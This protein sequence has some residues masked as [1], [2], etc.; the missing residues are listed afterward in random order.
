ML[1]VS[2][3]KRTAVVCETN[4]FG[5]VQLAVRPFAVFFFTVPCV[6]LLLDVWRDNHLNSAYVLCKFAF[7]AIIKYTRRRRCFKDKQLF[8]FYSLSQRRRFYAVPFVTVKRNSREYSTVC[9]TNDSI[10]F[11]LMC[12]RNSITVLSNDGKSARI[13]DCFLD[14]EHVLDMSGK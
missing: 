11:L 13:K 10:V 7:I 8:F 1:K 12:R 4:V 9:P 5:A 2:L 3:W 14:E 6:F